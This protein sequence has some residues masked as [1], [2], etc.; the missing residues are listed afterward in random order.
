MGEHKETFL[1]IN[2]K[3]TVELRSGSIKFKNHFKQL[4]APFKI[5]ADFE[6]N[7]KRVKSSNRSDN[8]SYTEKYQAHV[9]C[10]FA[11]KV[12][13][14]DKRFNK[15]VVLYIGKNVVYSFID[16][17]PGEYDYCRVVIKNTLVII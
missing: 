1:K 17:I 8:A 3:Q 4:A 10:S 9:R 13:C 7:V 15:P 6:C 5:C 16:T 12:V 11:Y 2:D 14:V